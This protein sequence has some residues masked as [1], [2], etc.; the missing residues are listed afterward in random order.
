MSIRYLS[1][2]HLVRNP[3]A[4]S[5]LSNVKAAIGEVNDDLI[6][7]GTFSTL[8]VCMSSAPKPLYP[9]LIPPTGN[10]LLMARL[11]QEI[12]AKFAARVR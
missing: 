3:E 4:I 1:F 5:V 12:V 2:W 10:S 7:I 9:A 11:L 6:H 8:S